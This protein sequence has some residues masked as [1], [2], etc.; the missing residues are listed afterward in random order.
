MFQGLRFWCGIS[1]GFFRAASKTVPTKTVPL[2]PFLGVRFIKWS[3]PLMVTVKTQLINYLPRCSYHLLEG[4]MERILNEY[5]SVIQSV[6][7]V[8]K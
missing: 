4:E 1:P 5:S 8:R 2:T 7:L 6:I 3:M